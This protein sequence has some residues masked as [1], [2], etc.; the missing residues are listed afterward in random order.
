MKPR[1]VDDHRID[2]FEVVVLTFTIYILFSLG[3]QILVPVDPEV[4]KLLSFFDMISCIIFLIDWYRRFQMA[5]NRLKFSL[6]N[7]LDLIASIPFLYVFTYV[8]YVKFIRL[9]RIFRIIKIFGGVNRV[10]YYLRTN[11]IHAIKLIF[12]IMFLMIMIT[13]PV[14]I[15]NVEHNVG[16]IKTAEQALWWSYCTLSTIGYGDFYPV[17]TVGRILA[18]FVSV[19]GISLFG[20]ASGITIDYFVKS[21]KDEKIDDDATT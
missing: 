21:H 18:V 7:S 5:E 16:N 13:S 4:V 8:G 3:W 11:K 20:L 6:I 9:I 19:G 12:S 17:T 10:I 14:L 1:K 15:L 2:V